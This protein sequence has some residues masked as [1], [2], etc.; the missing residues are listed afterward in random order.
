MKYTFALISILL[1]SSG[2]YLLKVGVNKFSRESFRE[3]S[4]TTIIK[5]IFQNFYL[6]GGI[7]AYAL[8]MLF[9]LYVLSQME[10][11]KAY[12]LASIGYIITML[13]GF[14]LLNESFNL[15]KIIGALFIVFGVI[16]INNG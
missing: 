14:F 8:S 16:F 2:Q 11:S 6:W 1:G 15:I 10:L 12:P 9:W 5:E 13:L 7:S 4:I 3:N